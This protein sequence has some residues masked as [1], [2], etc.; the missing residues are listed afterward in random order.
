MSSVAILKFLMIFEQG[1]PCFHS[2]RGP[3]NYVAGPAEHIECG[4]NFTKCAIS[5]IPLNHP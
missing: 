4:L 5:Q 2:A 1:V 3:A